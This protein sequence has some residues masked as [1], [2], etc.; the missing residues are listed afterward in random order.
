MKKAVRNT[1][2]ALCAGTLCISTIMYRTGVSRK[3]YVLPKLMKLV[4]TRSAG[5]QQF[6]K[7]R[8][9]YN[10][11]CDW[12]RSQGSELKK[13][14]SFDGLA[15]YADY[16]PYPGSKTTVILCHG[17]RSTGLGDFGG[18]VRYIH[19]QLRLNILL[20]DERSHGKSEGSHM[21][22]GIKERFDI[23]DWANMIAREHPDH[24]LF[25]YGMSLGAASV[26][27]STTTDLPKSVC[28]L[29]ADCGFTSPDDVFRSVCRSMYHLPPF[30]FVDIAEVFTKIFAHFDCKQCSAAQALKNNDIPVLFIHGGADDFVPTWMSRKNFAACRSE[31]E[32]VIIDGAYHAN[33]YYV[34]FERYTDAFGAFIEKHGTGE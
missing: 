2:F 12:F 9:V 30:P 11:G 6:E 15:L 21:T 34:D 19:E 31:K 17:Y 32:L 10:E 27:M 7:V 3:L 8:H 18:I 25:L 5:Q 33:S 23:C 13:L 29:I 1:A 24:K 14:R 4:Q 28:G 22:Y 20:I 16:L 26:L